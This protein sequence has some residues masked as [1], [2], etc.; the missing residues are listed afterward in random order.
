QFCRPRSC[1]GAEIAAPVRRRS[2]ARVCV[3]S[4][5]A[6]MR[7]SLVFALAIAALAADAA[8]AAE[9]AYYPLP[10]GAGPHH[11][12]PAADGHVWYT[13]QRKGVLGRLDPKTGK[14]VEVA[15][16]QD[17]TPHGVVVGPDGA[18]WVTDGGQNAIVRV[19]PLSHAVK[20]FTLPKD[21]PYANLNT[22][23]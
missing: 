17:S 5:E 22:L 9:V 18:A 8:W 12:A 21:F 14:A 2:D 20:L 13:G 6:V 16:G 3:S 7:W 4:K 15:L 11:V 1:R 19:D 10:A 23:T